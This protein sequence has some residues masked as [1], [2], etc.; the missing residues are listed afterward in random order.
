MMQMMGGNKGSKKY[1]PLLFPHQQAAAGG[2]DRARMMS[3]LKQ[4]NSHI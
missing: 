3:M 2:A 1:L 4:S